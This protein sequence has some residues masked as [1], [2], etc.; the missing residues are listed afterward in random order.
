MD[1]D[2]PFD[3]EAFLAGW[4]SPEDTDEELEYR[5]WRRPLIIAVALATVIAMALVP[6]YN[7]INGSQRLVAA[8]GLEVCGFDYCIV[9]E[10]LTD[11]GLDQTMARLS[12]IRL[13]DEEAV[14]LA[15]ALTSYMGVEPVSVLVVEQIEGGID[16]RY[17]PTS[18]T[19]VVDRPVVAWTIVHEVAH[20]RAPSHG[21]DFLAVMIELTAWLS[22]PTDG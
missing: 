15:N 13:S 11:A 2:L 17:D 1:P 8:N 19:V 18:R 9:Q 3:E 14:R 20:A 12:A 4:E 10:A 5:P 7:L 16:G 22:T 21:S 6:L